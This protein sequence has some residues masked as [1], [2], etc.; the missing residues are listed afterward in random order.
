MRR[1]GIVQIQVERRYGDVTYS[2]NEVPYLPRYMENESVGDD[3]VH[4]DPE[5]YLSVFNTL[6]PKF[7]VPQG[8]DTLVPSACFVMTSW[9]EI[10][11]AAPGVHVFLLPLISQQ[12]W[13][14][15]MD[16]GTLVNAV[17]GKK[18]Y[19][20]NVGQD[21]TQIFVSFT[22][23]IFIWC[24]IIILS[25]A[26]YR[27]PGFSPYAEMDMLGKVPIMDHEN[28]EGR[29]LYELHS[30]LHRTGPMKLERALKGV[31]LCVDEEG[32]DFELQAR[33]KP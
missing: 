30:R 13:A 6:Y 20:I 1:A 5:G 9:E 11:V 26:F 3:L 10:M 15:P 19:A 27:V 18:S 32:D 17:F 33:R 7:K 12:A 29:D 22:L 25:S 8:G 16:N 28:E 4:L 14:E 23:I 24:L 31:W 21:Q 2:L